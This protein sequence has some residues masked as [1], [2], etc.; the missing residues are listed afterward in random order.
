MGALEDG[1][2]KVETQ[3][4]THFSDENVNARQARVAPY[5]PQPVEGGFVPLN[6]IYERI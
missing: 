3:E 6:N 2:V 4:G 5:N 1:Y